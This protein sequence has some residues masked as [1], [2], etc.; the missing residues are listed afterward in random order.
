[1]PT[2]NAP[3]SRS[4]SS[5]SCNSIISD[6]EETLENGI[7]DLRITKDRPSS[8]SISRKARRIRFYRN[9]DKFFNGVVIPVTQ[10]RYR[11][12]IVYK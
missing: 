3:P 8:S 10:E 6:Y 12:R 11:C 5:T 7:S 2:M 9:G 1:M 4:V